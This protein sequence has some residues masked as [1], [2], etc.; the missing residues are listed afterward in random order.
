M[1]DNYTTNFHYV[2][3]KIGR[4][5]F[6]IWGVKE[7]KSLFSQA[8]GDIQIAVKAMEEED[9]SSS[10]HPL[11]KHYK[12]LQCE[13]APLDHDHDDFKVSFSFLFLAVEKSWLRL[14]HST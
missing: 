3:N 5:H 13:L 12:S 7:L 14:D 11:D 6:L 10:E 4:M 1:K 8:L 9:E 2:T